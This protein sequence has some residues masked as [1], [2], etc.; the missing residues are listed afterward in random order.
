MEH[1]GKEL[2]IDLKECDVKTFT[3]ES[4]KQYF[5]D[6]CEL[7]KME[8]EDFHFWDYYGDPKGYKNAPD[9]LKGVSAIQFIR[10]SN[11]TIHT[12]DVSKQCLINIFSCKEFCVDCTK[13]FTTKWFKGRVSNLDI[14]ARG[15]K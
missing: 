7:I 13:E 1:Y 4:I 14:I 9:H 3:R 12:L 11:I 6:L 5:I 10:T 2:I 15:T 8:R